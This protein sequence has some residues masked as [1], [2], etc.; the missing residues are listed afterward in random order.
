[1]Q[2]SVQRH[3]RALYDTV[4]HIETDTMTITIRWM[5]FN[6]NKRSNTSWNS[7]TFV[8]WMQTKCFLQKDF[9]NSTKET[10]WDPKLNDFRLNLRN[11][12][13]YDDWRVK[14]EL[15]SAINPIH[16]FWLLC[17]LTWSSMGNYQNFRWV[18][19]RDKYAHQSQGDQGG[20]SVNFDW[21]L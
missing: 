17:V 13:V 4:W 18:W 11:C 14:Q 8:I 15:S 6:A 7:Q 1:M 2:S 3:C 12:W 21:F 16:L 19:N 9:S 10:I 20:I 5:H